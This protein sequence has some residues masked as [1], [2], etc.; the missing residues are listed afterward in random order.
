MSARTI[1]IR[2]GDHLVLVTVP[3]VGDR[4]RVV[5]RGRHTG[6]DGTV[7]LSRVDPWTLR[8]SALVRF[9]SGA[10]MW[11]TCHLLRVLR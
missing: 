7:V 2:R 1:P 4:V 6:E 8:P 3:E 9:S 5:G 10:E 11:K